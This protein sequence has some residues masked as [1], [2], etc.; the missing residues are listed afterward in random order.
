MRLT[1]LALTSLIVLAGCATPSGSG[2]SDTAGSASAS[3]AAPATGALPPVTV[4][5][6][7]GIAGMK[8]EYHVAPDGTITGATRTNPSVSK[9]L[10][11]TQLG[12]LRGLVAGDALAAEVKKSPIGPK[13]C[14]DAFQYTVTAGSVTVRGTDCGGL[15]NE[16]P[17]MWKIVKLVSEAAGQ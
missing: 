11:S 12:E 16:V 7:G 15:A 8:D 4:S 6:T 14:G 17:T 10:T 2:S 1:N 5:R 13:G 9:K 3:P